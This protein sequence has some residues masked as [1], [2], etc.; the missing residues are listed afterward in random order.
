M[1]KNHIKE[2][3]PTNWAINNSTAIYI[4]TVL[5]S[6][7][8]M[9][10]FKSIPKEQ[11]PDIVVPTIFVSTIY[12]G[13]SPEDIEN[14]ISKPLEKEIKSITG[15]KK[16]TSNSIQDVSLVVVEFNSGIDV[17]IAKQKISNAVDKAKSRL[18]SDLKN[19]PNV[20]EVNFSEF[21][22]M[23]I[24]VSGEY[25]LD[26]L[27]RYAEDLKDKIETLPEITR[28]D[29]IGALEREVQIN[30]DLYRMQAL[31]ITFGDIERAVASENVNISSGEIRIDDLRRTMRVTGE[32]RDVKQIGNILIRS[33]RGNL[34]YLKDIADVVDGYKEKQDFARLEGKPVITMNVI[35]RAGENLISGA[36][37]I[38]EIID[39]YKATKFPEGLNVVITGDTS[40]ETKVQL[41]DL[42]NTVIIGFI[43]VVII[44]MF[45]M[46]LQSAFFVGLAVPLSVL[47]ALLFM[48][49][50]GFTMN[51][52]VLFSFLLALGIIVDD[53]IV[54]IENTH[55]IFHQYDFDIK[56]AAKAAAGE[57]FIPVLA[58]TLTTIAP[59]FPL[60]FWPGIVGDFMKYLPITLILTLFASLL[61]AF[62]MN[63]VFAVS[64][65]KRDHEGR[66][67]AAK[68]MR[69]PLLIFII[70]G[71]LV[72][73]T[74]ATAIGNVFLV[75]AALTPVYYYVLEPSSRSF[76][77][78]VWPR[79]IGGYKNMVLALLK[80]RR[81][82]YTIL[83]VIVLFFAS[84]M[85]FGASNPKVTFFPQGDPNFAYVYIEMPIGT[86][87]TVT[88][89]VTR[90]VEERVYKVIGRNNP[91]VESVI[92]NVGIGAGDPRNPD[93]VATPHKG[94]VSVAFVDFEHRHNFSTAE[95]L[96]EIR[97]ATRDVPGARITA[98]K[99]ANGPPTGKPINIEISG[100][101][102]D[103]LVRIEDLVRDGITKNKIQGIED[104][105]SDLQR[106]KPELIVEIDPDRALA[107]GM[108]K[109]QI[110]LELR[111]ALFGKEI[112]KFRDA[113]DDAE[114]TLRLKPEYRD[115]VDDLLNMQVAFL[116]MSTGMF[117]QIPVSAVASVRYDNAFSS[118]NRKDQRRVLTLSSNVLSGFTA[119]EIVSQ[120]TQLAKTIDVPEGYEI[121]MTGEQEQQKETS[122]FLGVAFLGALALMFLILVLQFN[123]V[124]K[125]FIIFSTVIFSLIGVFLGYALTG[126]IFSIVMT[127]VGIFSLA[128]IVIR[129]GILL[130]EFIDELRARGLDVTEAIAEGGATRITPVILTASAA[131]LGLIPL[132]IGVNIDFEGLFA[133]LEPHFFLGGDNVAFWGPL[134]W[135]MIFGLIVATFL[136]LVVVPAMYLLYLK[137]KMRL[138]PEKGNTA[139][140]TAHV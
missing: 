89:S 59:F 125:P 78:N 111:T 83:G 135:T 20:Q 121:R 132:A 43:L 28:V 5:I 31:G 74:G 118:I 33:T 36:D 134:A 66:E 86:D 50:L 119:N 130:M 38:K 91:N 108:S 68:A 29:L 26:H 65:M 138:R 70:L 19:D 87:A 110:A 88:D 52:I 13:A 131:I 34:A 94:K 82:I 17:D 75:L 25:P 90:I 116:D 48:P 105:Q 77:D 7:A 126:Q 72:H 139:Q 79:V 40:Q 128:G 2:F 120:I 99:E 100:E 44:L 21:P 1:E 109:A 47:V 96:E 4:L 12:P 140:E 124:V 6:F 115:R 123:S 15:I 93:R 85:I 97:K 98:D 37:K 107:V 104:L 95:C 24:N 42:I 56:T 30:V 35:K 129:N 122:D 60:L 14:L 113:D 127:G 22:I 54:V 18:P 9:F 63:T 73:L 136:T 133:R 92:S 39:E 81:P 114:I 76:Q 71:V 84:I 41:N 3:K 117:K 64:F 58:G 102:F 46:G 10:I 51:V 23:N 62:I 137:V 11:F 101:D 55:R 53:A 103:E 8:G 49:S 27:K 106:N 112:S 16:V 32:F 69:R 57:V 61:V 45:F 80:G 67:P